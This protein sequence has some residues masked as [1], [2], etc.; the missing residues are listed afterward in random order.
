MEGE[1]GGRRTELLE[2]KS[3][4]QRT[5]TGKGK[6]REGDGGQGVSQSI[7]QFITR[8]GFPLHGKQTNYTKYLNCYCVGHGRK[9]LIITGLRR[10]QSSVVDMTDS[11]L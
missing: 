3:F 10:L 8:I 7:K 6:E 9:R 5:S 11:S 1:G 4:E 2:K